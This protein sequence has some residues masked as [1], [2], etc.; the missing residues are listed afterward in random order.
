MIR[1]TIVARP[2]S[3]ALAI[4]LAMLAAGCARRDPPRE[5]WLYYATNL[6]D[7]ARVDAL[8]SVW[9]RAAAA[10]YRRVVLADSK[11]SRLGEMDDAYFANVRRVRALAARLGLEIVPTL[12]PVGRS[13]GIL[14]LDPNLAE[15]LP[16]RDAL[17]EMHGGEGRLIPDPP[18]RLGAR[19]DLV[20]AE[21]SLEDGS[22]TVRNP[23]RRARFMHRVRV[24][25]FRCYHVSVRVRTRTF[26]GTPLIQ[27]MAAGRPISFTRTMGV[28]STQDWTT[29][30][31][32]FHSLDHRE[33]ALWFGV[34]EA[35]RGTLEWR[36]WRIEESGPFNVL[37]RAGA[38]FEI[39]GLVEG[40]DYRPVIDPRLGDHPWRGQYDAWHEPV[41][42]R[43]SLPDGARFRASW[44]QAAVVYGGQVTC[45]PAAPELWPRLADEAARVRK[46]FEPRTVLMMHDEIRAMNWDESC[47]AFGPTPGAILARH[48][49][50]CTRLLAGTRVLVWGDMFDP[51]QNAVRD[52]DLVRGDLAG[53]WEGLAP[54]VGIVNWNARRAAASSRFF[55]RRG[56]AQVIAGYYD[57]EPEAIRSWL[58]AVRG[59]PKVYAVMYTTWRDD[60]GDLE[61]FAR[62]VRR[63]T[64]PP[65]T[66][67]RAAHPATPGRAFVQ[68]EPL[69]SISV[70]FAR[71][72][73]R[74][75]GD[76]RRIEA[77][78]G[79]P[80]KSGGLT[81]SGL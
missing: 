55:A 22:A 76:P 27:V 81:A 46:T 34:W 40:R 58:S 45:C 23:R 3:L 16:I 52:G 71:R 12:F 42:I 2:I 66:A 17:F 56:H 41:P 31:L 62:A 1:R 24:A 7:S 65:A 43:A 75:S 38:P 59:V 29:H 15:G 25:P 74:R 57:G 53:S 60:Y 64:D 28:A 14:A 37:H 18:V 36:D 6:A 11:F 80:S 19:P 21:V 61:A 77:Q 72:G 8:A 35:A 50:E 63:S 4:A 73:S 10:G 49:R 67:S 69:H 9:R 26:S 54:E 48:V 68:D 30:H 32:A 33:V 47:R 78:G 20:D 39:S 13:N 51:H 5:L 70:P 79:I 44:Y